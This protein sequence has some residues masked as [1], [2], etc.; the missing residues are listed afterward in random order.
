MNVH[1][2]VRRAFCLFS[3]INWWQLTMSSTSNLIITQ[4]VISIYI[5]IP[6][7]VTIFCTL[8]LYSCDLTKLFTSIQMSTFISIFWN[9]LVQH[10]VLLESLGGFQNKNIP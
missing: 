3:M 8:K 1:F 9:V 5:Q 10:E 7:K 2:N 4:N 6:L